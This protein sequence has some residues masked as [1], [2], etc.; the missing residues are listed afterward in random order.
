M[1]ANRSLLAIG[2]GVIAL[3]VVTLAVVLLTD[4]RSSPFPADA[5]EAALQGYIG[6][7]RVAGGVGTQIPASMPSSPLSTPLNPTT[8]PFSNTSTDMGSV[9]FV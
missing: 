9:S 3:V 4:E 2:A 1:T 8:T 5:P 7:G 6:T